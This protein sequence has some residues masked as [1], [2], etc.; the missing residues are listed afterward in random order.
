MINYERL[1]AYRFEGVEQS[2]RQQVWDV[3]ASDI[4]RRMGSPRTVLD[5]AA[6][7]GEFITAVPT[8]DRWG[9]DRHIQF[10]AQAAGVSAIVGDILDVALP[11]AY[12]DG[13]FVSNFL[14]HL[15]TPDE[16]AVVLGRLHEAMAVGGAIAV[17]G[18]NFRYCSKQYFDCADHVLALTHISVAE[19]LYAAGFAVETVLPKFLPYSFR[20]VLPPSSRLTSIYLRLALAQRLLG[21]QF[22]VIARKS[23]D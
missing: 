6:G 16:V 18:P 1:Y 12:F 20:G 22:L 21:K 23:A 8:A 14:E 9:V 3:I 11:A 19:H 4:Y 13:V 2:S 10:D 17:L 5:P 15:A 7:R